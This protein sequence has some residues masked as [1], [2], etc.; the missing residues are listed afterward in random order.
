MT[1]SVLT[2]RGLQV[3]Y[4]GSIRALEDVDL[5]VEAGQTVA[6]LGANGAG[7]TTL[8][9]TVSGLLAHH[10]GCVTSGS[11]ELFGSRLPQGNPAAAVG[12][13]L[14]QVMEGRRLFRHLTVE[15]NVRLGAATLPRA[16]AHKR[17]EDMFERFPLLR[18][19]RAEPAGLLS[20]GQQQTVAIA[21]AL[22]SSPRL[23]VLDEP[24]LGLSPVAIQ[25]VRAVLEE[26]K[27]DGLTLLLV[28]QNVELALQLADHAYVMQ[29]GRVIASGTT[30]E[31]GKS[32]SVKDL[33]L[34]DGRSELVPSAPRRAERDEKV[35]LPWMQ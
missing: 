30:A 6:L 23:L 13:G 22:V 12:A 31:L 21:R 34:G 9:R 19:R 8:L 32:S 2:V 15:E 5:S 27:R 10:G 11:I 18:E 33:Y 24:S 16:E 3:R 29:R 14:T 28:E 17:A 1:A 26:L 4:G 25:Q 20:G 7:K 35:G